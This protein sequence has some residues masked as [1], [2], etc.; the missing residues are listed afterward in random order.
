M[1][2]DREY[3]REILGSETE[4]LVNMLLRFENVFEGFPQAR[5]QNDDIQDKDVDDDED[6]GEGDANRKRG[7]GQRGDDGGGET[8]ELNFDGI[9]NGEKHHSTK[10]ASQK[11]EE[12][13]GGHRG[14]IQVTL[15][16]GSFRWW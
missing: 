14:R 11:P 12:R 5:K 13:A 4:A 2:P 8:S 6:G 10:P 1:A 16:R 7:S 3:L 9:S 15:Q